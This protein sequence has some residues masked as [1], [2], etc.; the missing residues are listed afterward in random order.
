MGEEPGRKLADWIMHWYDPDEKHVYNDI[1]GPAR[2]TSGDAVG[3]LRP[4]RACP[5]RR[6]TGPRAG[7]RS[8]PSTRRTVP[9]DSDLAAC[10]KVACGVLCEGDGECGTDGDLDNCRGPNGVRFDVYHNIVG[11]RTICAIAGRSPTTRMY[12]RHPRPT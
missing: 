6:R 4:A 5:S 11:R 7:R 3:A 10:D 1:N 12:L 8:S 2:G 9:A